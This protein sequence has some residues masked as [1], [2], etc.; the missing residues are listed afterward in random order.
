LELALSEEGSRYEYE[1]NYLMDAVHFAPVKYVPIETV[2][3]DDNR[4]SHFRPVV[5]SCR[6]YSRF[7][8]FLEA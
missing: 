7:L 2:Y 3:E 5:D 8:R 1:M 6:I 4:A